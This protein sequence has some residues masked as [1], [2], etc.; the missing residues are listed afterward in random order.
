MLRFTMIGLA[1]SWIFGF[2]M[3]IRILH[4]DPEIFLSNN[5]PG[6]SEYNYLFLI[7]KKHRS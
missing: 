2:W 6:I 7:I 4:A 3:E 5:K 1:I